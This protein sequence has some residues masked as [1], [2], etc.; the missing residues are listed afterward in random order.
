M[1]REL[2]RGRRAECRQRLRCAVSAGGRDEMVAMLS[3]DVSR[4]PPCGCPLRGRTAALLE[5]VWRGGRGGWAAVPSPWE[6]RQTQKNSSV[7]GEC[8]KSFF[9]SITGK[10]PRVLSYL[11]F[12]VVPNHRP[13]LLTREG[14]Y[15]AGALCFRQYSHCKGL[16]SRLQTNKQTNQQNKAFCVASHKNGGFGVSPSAPRAAHVF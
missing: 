13:R 12:L 2:C 6:F 9:L 1:G 7:Y 14:A 15:G 10:E 16:D 5:G 11:A 8:Q 3:L 4:R